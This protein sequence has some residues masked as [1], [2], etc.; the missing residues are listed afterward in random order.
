[1][2]F[3]YPASSPPTSTTI[4]LVDKPDAAQSSFVL[5]TIGPPRNTPDYFALR[6]MNMLFG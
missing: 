5:G 1:V 6:V 2:S 3:A 4:Y